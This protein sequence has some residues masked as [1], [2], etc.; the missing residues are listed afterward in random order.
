LFKSLSLA[1]AIS[2]SF[3]LTGCLEV[4]DKNNDDN[5]ALVAALEAQ[6]KILEE[7]QNDNTGPITLSGNVADYISEEPINGAIIRYKLGNEWSEKQTFSAN[8]FDLKELP[9]NS[10]FVIEI[11]SANNEFLTRAFYGTTKN[12]NA[13]QNSIQQLGSLFVNKGEVVEIE[14]LNEL[15]NSAVEGI[16]I[17]YNNSVFLN[18]YS[19]NNLQNISKEHTTYASFNSVS[20]K[21]DLIIP[22]AISGRVK[23]E[24]DIDRDG[25]N[26]Y[27]LVDVDPYNYGYRAVSFS[28]LSE[29]TVIYA[30]AVNASQNFEIR[31]NV[32]DTVGK[33]FEGLELF[34]SNK[35]S[36][37]VAA[38]FDEETKQYV[39]TYSGTADLKLNMPSFVSEDQV[40]Y[41]SGNISIVPKEQGIY[42]DSNYFKS[43]SEGMLEL[44]DNVLNLT[45]IP[46][47]SSSNSNNV[48]LLTDEIDENNYSLNLFFDSAVEVV[49]NEIT[50]KQQ[51]V[52]KVTRG[53]D[54]DEDVVPDGITTINYIDKMIDI[55]VS[56]KYNNTFVQA[57]PNIALDE[58]NYRYKVGNLKNQETD[59]T[60]NVNR[61]YDFDVEK[62]VEPVFSIEDIS[63]DNNNGLYQNQLI[64][65]HNT[66]GV[67][68]KDSYS[69]NNTR[70]Y[71][72]ESI[73]TLEYLEISI[74]KKVDNGDFSEMY[75]SRTIVEN[76]IP[77]I[78]T[79][80]TVSTALNETIKENI[81]RSIYTYT[82]LPDGKWYV[83]NESYLP[84]NDD[85]TGS[86][87]S[88][89]INYLYQVK[90][91][92]EVQSGT[93][94]LKVN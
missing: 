86:E 91:S 68:A 36:H 7:Q 12:V 39:F 21:Y 88:V 93:T 64:K 14:I 15:T 33:V 57:I 40:I 19:N 42:V 94:T 71:L 60:F 27:D 53:N 4:E 76:G 49:E 5:A 29:N 41:R 78:N 48:Y 16:E 74:I 23:L 28:D 26:D 70:F 63:I 72:P 18:D 59:G 58:G 56:N 79:A 35:F 32:I 30:Q 34:A 47:K 75:K 67:S 81:Y 9:G 20:K 2:T 44:V 55:S 43:S 3:I 83:F 11:S 10:D 92:S 82:N 45:V 50:L 65:T 37:N 90:G 1:L 77:Q 51:N 54:S 87:N 22:T 8:T 52:L 17:S 38:I 66:A 73:Q 25:I 85:V 89:T 31:V 69:S 62:K 13:N 80:Y 61:S 46:Y 84:S 6:N 24:T